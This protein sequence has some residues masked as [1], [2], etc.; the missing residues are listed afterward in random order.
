MGSRV[1]SAERIGVD[2][3]LGNARASAPHSTVTLFAR[4]PGLID[5]ASPEPGDVIGKQLE[6]D[7]R[8]DGG[9]QGVAGGMRMWS[10][11]ASVVSYPPR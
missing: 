7:G 10:S 5:L 9:D 4:F 6:G 1:G 8:R 2:L 11:M 3:P